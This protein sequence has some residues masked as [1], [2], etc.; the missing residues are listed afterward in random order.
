MKRLLYS[1]FFLSLLFLTSCG[2]MQS[3]STVRTAKSITLGDPVITQMPTVVEL[4]VDSIPLSA[5]TVWQNVPF[6]QHATKD[7]QTELLIANILEQRNADVL[8]QP[9]IAHDTK[10][11][12]RYV[13]HRLSVSGFPARYVNFHTATKE[14]WEIINGHTT[15]PGNQPCIINIYNNGGNTIAPKELKEATIPI[16]P[17]E[18][19]KVKEPRT[20]KSVYMGTL[21]LGGAIGPYYYGGTVLTSHGAL[22]KKP[23]ST[24]FLGLGCGALGLTEAG[25]ANDEYAD[26]GYNYSAVLYG[27]LRMTLG[28]SSHAPFLDIKE[29][30]SLGEYYE[31]GDT[32]GIAGN[33]FDVSLG[34]SLFTAKH[35]A[36]DFYVGYL[37]AF[38]PYQTYSDEYYNSDYHLV[39]HSI[40]AGFILRFGK[41]IGR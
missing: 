3:T 4:E 35:S 28:K 37:N 2:T 23:K 16:Q 34:F 41:N 29:G 1:V 9:K 6:K 38:S 22:F 5:D 19:P 20:K 7:N 39:S 13:E 40:R 27:H 21:E 15:T 25:Y 10:V 26:I 11:T 33:Y 36:L 14:D 17:V 8:V 12:G 18:Q 31:P 32:Y 24:W 30:V